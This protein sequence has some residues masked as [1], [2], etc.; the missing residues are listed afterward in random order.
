MDQD[1]SFTDTGTITAL[2]VRLKETRIPRAK[3]LLEKVNRGEV[4]SD[5]DIRFLKRVY[6]DNRS[7]QGLIKR[8]PEYHGLIS[9]FLG[10]Y[11]EIINKGVENEKSGKS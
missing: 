8:H 9:R 4:L 7:I 6:Q 5:R 3:R 11:I 1:Q 10:L 2:M